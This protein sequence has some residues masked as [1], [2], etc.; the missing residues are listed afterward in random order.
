[1][2]PDASP[3]PLAY[4]R[5]GP[6]RAFGPGD[7][8]VAGLF[9][10]VGIAF[11]L[12]L[13]VA[14]VQQSHRASWAHRDLTVDPRAYGRAI[15]PATVARLQNPTGLYESHALLAVAAAVGLGLAVTLLVAAVAPGSVGA[16][17]LRTYARWK[18]AGAVF[19]TVA[20]LIAGAASHTFWVTATR[21]WPV[22][23]TTL[24]LVPAALLLAAAWAPAWWA[25][26]RSAAEVG[27]MPSTPEA[28][29]ATAIYDGVVQD[30]RVTLAAGAT[31]PERAR[32]FVVLPD[33]TPPPTPADAAPARPAVHVPGPRLARPED[34]ARLAKRVIELVDP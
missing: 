27:M 9:G 6:R 29:M 5:P 34:A 30:G 2:S 8:V 1:M 17:R 32:V 23:S 18:P 16:R 25:R 22:G 19:T 11:N 15:D 28:R 20:V 13:I 33:P 12:T 21:H 31:L 14:A 24:P 10:V 7:R 4:A 26:S 3:H